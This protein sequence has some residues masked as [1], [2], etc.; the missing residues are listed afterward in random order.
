M[1]GVLIA[2][3]F[4]YL[5]MHNKDDA[6]RPTIVT[7]KRCPFCAFDNALIATHCAYCDMPFIMLAQ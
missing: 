3:E 6:D 5:I 2:V 7:L 1:I 4:T